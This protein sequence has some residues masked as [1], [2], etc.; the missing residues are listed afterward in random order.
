MN[1]LQKEYT[2][3]KNY[4]YKNPFE[5][6]KELFKENEK[7]KLITNPKYVQIAFQVAKELNEENIASLDEDLKVE[8]NFKES[9][10]KTT[11]ILS[12]KRKQQLNEFFI[13]KNYFYKNIFEE[14]KNYLKNHD[15][16]TL[17]AKREE[18]GMAFKVAKE[19]V[20]Q[21][22]ALYDE[23]LKIGRNFKAGKGKTEIY[24][25]LKKKPCIQEYHIK[26]N[27][28][29][30]EIV[31]NMKQLFEKNEKITMVALPG[32][33][34][35]AFKAAKK[36][37]DGGIALYD[38]E[39]K[40]KRNFK[41]EKGKTKAFISLKKRPVPIQSKNKININ[42]ISI[43]KNSDYDEIIRKSINLLETNEKMN[44]EAKPTDVCIAFKVAE[45]LNNKGISTYDDEL[46]VE[47]NFK[48]EKERTKVVI[49][50]KKKA[51]IKEYEIGK[52]STN[53]KIVKDIKELFKEYDKIILVALR[54]KVGSAFTACKV[55]FEE[56][57]A[58]YDDE[59]KIKRNLKE[60]L[61]STKACISIK[62]KIKSS[63]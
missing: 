5:D 45:D 58:I 51:K 42:T 33:I 35:T 53:E 22:I 11:I 37:I 16:I 50:L 59:L 7:I 15:K 17:K 52:K 41:V 31:Q 54:E 24:I 8:R 12:L 49:S 29:S 36:L 25:S 18:V 20:E 32:E 63:N 44:L 40:I 10:R 39:L 61:G 28:E 1:T 4:I 43:Q 47:R 34:P 46:K 13:E 6:L 62:K 9:K 57:I 14:I 21:G 60:G 48:E 38:E 3:D 27:E 2:I 19:L 30:S 55:L 26:K 56:G 23:E